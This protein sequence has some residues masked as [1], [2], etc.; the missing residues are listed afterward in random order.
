MLFTFW[1]P[2]PLCLRISLNLSSF[3]TADTFQMPCWRRFTI[4]K[5]LL[6]F[7]LLV[8]AS[9]DKDLYLVSYHLQFWIIRKTYQFLALYLR[10]TKL[11]PG[12][13]LQLTS[14][15]PWFCLPWLGST[16]HGKQC[17]QTSNLWSLMSPLAKASVLRG[18]LGQ[19]FHTLSIY[20]IPLLPLK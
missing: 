18:I 9:L 1:K 5:S 4:L 6:L 7:K 8:Y 3:M 14:A 16:T 19:D 11:L 13:F 20:I 15:A 17:F 12:G 10:I 2:G